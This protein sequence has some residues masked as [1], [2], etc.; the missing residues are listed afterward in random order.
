MSQRQCRLRALVVQRQADD[1]GL[2]P[3]DAGGPGIDD[4]RRGFSRLTKPSK[5]RQNRMPC[6]IATFV[7]GDIVDSADCKD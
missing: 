5:V 2:S 4:E 6:A 3:I 1:F 7:I